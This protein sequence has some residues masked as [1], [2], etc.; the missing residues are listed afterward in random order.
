MIQLTYWP[1]MTSTSLQGPT[2]HCYHCYHCHCH[3][4]IFSCQSLHA[5][6]V[7]AIGVIG[8]QQS[9]WPRLPDQAKSIPELKMLEI[10]RNLNMKTRKTSRLR[11][12]VLRPTSSAVFILSCLE[13][14][15]SWNHSCHRR[16]CQS[17]Y[18]YPSCHSPRCC[19]HQP[20]HWPASL[21]VKWWL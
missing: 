8:L 6:V 3:E 5:F 16:S 21:R 13:C 17:C 4:Q 19:C 15:H 11:F 12:I 7:R 9:T 18:R 20:R 1:K 10:S 2:D 14:W